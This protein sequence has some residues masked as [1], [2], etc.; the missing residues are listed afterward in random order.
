MDE[1]RKPST[2]PI[3]ASMTSSVR[4]KVV[5]ITGP[6][7]GIGAATARLLAARG[8]RLA[9]AGMEPERLAPLAAEL[10]EAHRWFECDVT[11]QAAV[12]RAV[13][14]SVEALGR[15]DVVIANAGVASHGS[16]ATTPMA[17]MARTIDVNLTGVVR[18]VSA[19]LPHVAAAR[20]YYLL[21]SS[22]SALAPGAGL[23]T[24]AATKIGS[25]TSAARCAWSSRTGEWA[26]AWHTRAGSTPRWC[27]GRSATWRASTRCCRC[28]RGPSAG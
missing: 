2:H 10:G 15:I 4:D 6:A 14:G 13:V 26:W 28:S 24:Y 17:A 1:S 22:A 3:P 20:G 8:A 7:R 23:A 11:D 27:V 21:V 25:S 9:L 19:T 12:E 5:L 18:T 16:V